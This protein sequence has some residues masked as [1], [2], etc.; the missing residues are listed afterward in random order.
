MQATDGIWL[1]LA[2]ALGIGM[3]V[4]L[5]RE[6]RKDLGPRRISAGIRTFSVTALLGA[7]ALLLGGPALLLA[8][9]LA[10]GALTAVAYWQSEVRDM[11]LTTGVALLLTLLL[12]GLATHDALLASALGVVLTVLLAR[13]ASLHRFVRQVIT[14][15]ELNDALVLAAATL[16]VLPLL[17]D[18]YLGPYQ[19]LNPRTTWM[20]VILM[21][22]VG[23]AGHVAQR[24]LG[25][26]AGLMATGF[27]AGFVSSTATIAAMGERAQRVP[28]SFLPAVAGAVASSV[29]T[30][31]LLVLVLAA[32]SPPALVAMAWP[33]AGAAAAVLA[34]AALFALRLAHAPAPLPVDEGHA[35]SLTKTLGLALLVSV[36][37]V[38]SSAMQAAFGDTGLWVGAAITGLADAH[39]S[40]VSVAARVAAGQLSAEQAVLSILAGLSANTAVKCVA[41][42]TL[43]GWRFALSV[44][45]GL[46]LM[47]AVA[48]LA[49]AGV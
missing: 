37:T 13:R 46:V 31:V 42:A 10:V 33:L 48:W 11:G 28:A 4:G 12:G 16:V 35:F 21:M 44:I 34:Y 1:Q 5:E 29:A 25:A 15:R 14:E 43:G 2:A 18:R 39:A 23:A 8:A 49:W 7:V 19:A 40:A 20:V 22:A 45:P 17:P 9:V 30:V 27:A 38:A 6:R 36:V 32:T 24:L 3:L 41:A 26:R 47:V